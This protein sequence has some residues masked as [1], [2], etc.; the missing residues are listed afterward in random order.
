MWHGNEGRNLLGP[1]SYQLPATG[2]VCA[3]RGTWEGG[4]GRRASTYIQYVINTA[5]YPPYFRLVALLGVAP[6]G[7]C[8]F[9]S[10]VVY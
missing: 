9:F 8:V 6:H 10:L 7:N 5:S 4:G 3:L 2:Y 1:T